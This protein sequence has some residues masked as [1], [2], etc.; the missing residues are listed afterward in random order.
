M[1]K[2]KILKLFILMISLVSSSVVQ[3]NI[4]ETNEISSVKNYIDDRSMVLFNI[5]GTLY[6]PSTTLS[7][8]QWREYFAE[9]VKAIIPD[10][11]VGENLINRIKNEIVENIPKKPVEE[12]TPQLIADLQERKIPV[13]GITRKRVTTP[14]ADNFGLI[15]SNHLKSIGID[16]EKTVEYS[17]PTNK[18]S[19][20]YTFAY[21][22][23]FTNQKPVIPSLL[24]F[25][26][27]NHYSR[28]KIV[29]IDN[30]KESLE[31]VAVALG[32]TSI[33][34]TGLRY[35]RADV[36]KTSF[37]PALGT[38]EFFAYMNEDK[39][40]MTDDEAEKILS[41]N[42]EVDYQSRLDDLIRKMSADS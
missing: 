24:K 2:Q 17:D 20:L 7:D 42:P 35:S 10:A 32:S 22:M 3:G 29:M 25:L 36:Q 4:I 15:T 6:A 27:D 8:H 9:R 41:E 28:S 26:E 1:L 13:F 12:I 16:L 14:Y 5:T 18:D 11:A 33:G 30:D 19:E 21:G 39:K 38:I 37:N 34:F 23:I 40:V 31:A